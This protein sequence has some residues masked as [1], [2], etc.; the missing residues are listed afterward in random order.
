MNK[1]AKTDVDTQNAEVHV[2]QIPA[3]RVK[4][5]APQVCSPYVRRVVRLYEKVSQVENVVVETITHC[6]LDGWSVKFP[7]LYFVSL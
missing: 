3:K 7:T 1:R 4:K 5:K 6:Q 2:E